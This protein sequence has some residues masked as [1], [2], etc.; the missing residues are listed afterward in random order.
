MA[1][2]PNANPPG[3]PAVEVVVP[4]CNCPDLE[5]IQIVDIEPDGTYRYVAFTVRDPAIRTGLMPVVIVRGYKRAYDFESIID[6]VLLFNGPY[7]P[8]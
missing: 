7:L 5:N 3:L 6:E 4:N 8:C 2:D 1:T